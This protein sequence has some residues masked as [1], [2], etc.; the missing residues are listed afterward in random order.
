MVAAGQGCRVC[1]NFDR[2]QLPPP[3][4]KTVAAATA[5]AKLA[6]KQQAAQTTAVAPTEHT[7]SIGS[8]GGGN[9][10]R[11][12]CCGGS[13]TQTNTTKRQRARCAAASAGGHHHHGGRG[14]SPAECRGLG[15][16]LILK[17]SSNVVLVAGCRGRRITRQMCH[18]PHVF[19]VHRY[20]RGV[21]QLCCS[22]SHP[23]SFT[24]NNM[25]AHTA[26]QRASHAFGR[27]LANYKAYTTCEFSC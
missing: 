20:T 13:N 8:C 2:M 10:N 17:V 24:F 23:A 4:P 6:S 14:G 15:H 16:L 22:C 19:C 26:T 12:G 3:P 9:S 1:C 11:S 21:P 7:G 18:P 25:H 27:V 5:A